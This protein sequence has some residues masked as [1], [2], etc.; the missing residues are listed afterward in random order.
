[1]I[2]NYV[3]ELAST[4]LDMSLSYKFQEKIHI[5]LICEAVGAFSPLMSHLTDDHFLG[6]EEIPSDRRLWQRM[7]SLRNAQDEFKK[8]RK[9]CS[10]KGC[11]QGCSER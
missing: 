4:Y 3:N 5:K 8:L 1:M 7:A 9:S 10:Q 6:R 2:K 11:S